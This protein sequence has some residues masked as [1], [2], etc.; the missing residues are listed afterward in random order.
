[1]SASTTVETDLATCPKTQIQTVVNVLGTVLPVEE[2]IARAH[3][4]GALVFAKGGPHCRRVAEGRKVERG[5]MLDLRDGR[6][7]ELA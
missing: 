2:I 4:Q 1:M 7:D 3:A 5:G 6:L